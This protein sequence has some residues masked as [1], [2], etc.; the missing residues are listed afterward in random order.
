VVVSLGLASAQNTGGAGTDTLAGIESLTGSAFADTLSGNGLANV[1]N[2]G[3]GADNLYGGG[4]DDTYVVDTLSD[5]IGEAAGAGTDLVLSSVSY[6]LATNV[7]N[8]T[9]TGTADINATGN[10]A[11]NTLTGNDGVNV[12]NGLAGAD[13]MIGMGGNDHY[14]MDDAGDQVIE[15]AGGGTDI[16][17]TS[18]SYTTGANVEHARVTTAAAVDLT[19]NGLDNSLTGNDGVNVLDGQA[20]ADFLYG[21]LGNDIYYADSIY[22]RIGEIGPGGVDTVFASVSFQLGTNVENLTLTGSANVNAVGNGI[23]N[24]LIGNSGAN[25]V[26]GAGG[27]DQLTGGAGADRFVFNSTADSG[28]SAATADVIHDF[29]QAEGDRIQLLGIDA[30]E[31]AGGDQAFAFI[32]TNAFTGTAGELRFEQSNGNTFVTGDTDGDAAADFMIQLDGLHTLQTGDFY[33]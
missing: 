18:V 17:Y 11:A 33:L 22:D 25:A 13:V 24:V 5:R 1:L 26:L 31:G 28:S 32:G 8:L 7:E 19:G 9:L 30:D 15:A 3:A 12:L 16:V 27:L 10:A 4:G 29:S 2:G 21:G 20:G 6:L 23:D 14:V